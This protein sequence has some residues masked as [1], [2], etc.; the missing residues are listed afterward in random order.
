VGAEVARQVDREVVQGEERADVA[1]V[2]R[3]PR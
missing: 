3:R 1:A 2:R